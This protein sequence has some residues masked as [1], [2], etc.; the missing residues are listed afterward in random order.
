MHRWIVLPYDESPIARAGLRRAAGWLVAGVAGLR[1]TVHAASD[2]DARWR[3]AA[4]CS[5]VASSGTG[6]PC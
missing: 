6:G 4:H 5:H 1:A 2:G 3:S